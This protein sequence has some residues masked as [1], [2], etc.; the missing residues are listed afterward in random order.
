MSP[1]V[2]DNHGN[3]CYSVVGDRISKQ[4]ASA[5]NYNGTFQV[6]FHAGPWVDWWKGYRVEDANGNVLAKTETVRGARDSATFTLPAS[7]TV[8]LKIVI[9]KA[10]F[11]GIP[12]DVF[13]VPVNALSQH[14]N[15]ASD[16]AKG[17]KWHID[18]TYQ[19]D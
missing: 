18:Y 6:Q 8:G 13:Q 4:Y 10:G 14:E 16:G 19:T 17:T 7:N 11:L 5:G 9:S 2:A 15:I 3:P 1:V 12:K